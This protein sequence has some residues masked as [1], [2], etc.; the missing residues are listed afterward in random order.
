VPIFVSFTLGG[1]AAFCLYADGENQYVDKAEGV[2][3]VRQ[4]SV[5][6]DVP[7]PE[8]ATVRV[9]VSWRGALPEV[10]LTPKVV[11]WPKGSP[12]A[13]PEPSPES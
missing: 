1:K 10:A 6:A 3:Y 12:P 7:H 4:W 9:Q 8:M 5:R 11:L 2:T 13:W